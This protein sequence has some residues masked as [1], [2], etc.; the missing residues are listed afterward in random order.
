MPLPRVVA[1][2]PESP[3]ARAGLQP[4]DEIVAMNGEAPRDVIAYQLLAAEA[5]LDLD[6]LRG[7]L[8]LTVS[9]DNP[10]GVPLGVDQEDVG[11]V[12]QNALGL[13][14]SGAAP[15]ENFEVAGFDRS[16]GDDGRVHG[17][18]AR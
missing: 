2:T 1:V 5:E 4:G 6:V 11:E 8:G 16:A 17:N 15:E 13:A 3:A 7:G 18:F 12:A 9:V 10:D 14:G